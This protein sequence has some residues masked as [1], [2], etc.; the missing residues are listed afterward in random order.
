MFIQNILDYFNSINRISDEEETELEIKILL[1]PRINS[2]DFIKTQS[3]IMDDFKYID[4][5]KKIVANS[6]NFGHSSISQTINFIHTE[7][8]QM[9]VKQLH[10]K[11]GIQIKE[12]RKFYI[13]KSLIKPV[14]LVSNEMNQPSYKLSISNES[15]QK[16]DINSFDI[17]RF[18]LRYTIKF[19]KPELK[20]WKLELTLIKECKNI[21]ISQIKIIRDRLFK[22]NIDCDNFLD[23][24]DWKYSDRVE[25]EMEYIGLG[26]IQLS[27]IKSLDELWKPLYNQNKTYSDCVNQIAQI[28][29]PNM[30]DKFKSG[31]F[32]LKQLGSNPIELTKKCYDS[33]ILPNI[34]DFILTEKTD[35]I[36]SMIII[37]PKLGDCH[38]INKTYKYM[39]IPIIENEEINLIILDAEE[40]NTSEEFSVYYVFDCIWYNKNVS[41]LPFSSAVGL[42]KINTNFELTGDDRLSYIEKVTDKYEFLKLKDF[43]HLNKSDYSEQIKEL[44][45]HLDIS[46]NDSSK[47]LPETD[48]FIYISKYDNY[49]DTRN[50]KWKPI[51][52]MTIDF[53]VKKCPSNLLGIHPY[54]NKDEKTLYILFSGIRS[55]EYKKL[56]IQKF[57][58]YNNMF[59]QVQYKDAY[60]PIQFS[61]SSDPYAYLF[62]S[63]N[64]NLDNNIVELNRVDNEWKLFKVRSDRKI[65]MDRK[66]Y[67]GNYFKYAEYIWMNYSNPLTIEY[68]RNSTSDMNGYFQE[69][70]NS[71][72]K[73]SR[74]FNN[75]VKNTLLQMYVQ[76]K[77][78][79]HCNWVIDLACGKAQDLTK[80]ID[81]DIKNIL[82]I[83]IDISALTEVIHRKYTYI[84]NKHNNHLSNIFIKQLDL[85]ESYKKNIDNIC[86]SPFGILAN[87]VP[88][89]ICNL[90]LHYLIPNK[91]KIQN[92]CNLLNKLLEPGGIFIF[93]AF[94]GKKIF[95][96]LKETDTWHKY[97][98]GKLLFSIKKKYTGD[99]FTGLNQ[100]IDVLLPFSNGMYYTEYLINEDLLENELAKKKIT[101]INKDS[102]GI[103]MNKFK[104]NKPHFYKELTDI[105][106]EFISLYNFYVFNKQKS[107]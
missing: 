45:T 41:N 10:F 4:T 94:N 64:H 44:Q 14:Y 17:I 100:K 73:Y 27:D 19:I 69:D 30:I 99:V 63:D 57:K 46:N 106:S 66:T 76:N 5:I 24:V 84:N 37:Y 16:E 81:C 43:I 91:S 34:N 104:I 36:R 51:E 87:G 33:I 1:D 26:S 90:A 21:P 22:N 29:K 70:D 72:Y 105:D 38:I 61:P 65:D 15:Y 107:R 50:Y 28:I 49:N 2:P 3:A 93:T 62:W 7:K 32:G 11:N 6:V 88:L 68:L 53:V 39:K 42:D 52:K 95:D 31:Q 80:Y 59:K 67:Y 13:K 47:I 97:K 98:D 86:K 89:V 79:E 60:F 83:D 25:L 96:L 56:G 35:G 102:F 103:Y 75:F 20:N 48:G 85:S 78:D 55:N 74:K 23:M 54:I 18:R 77:S 82:M 101:L 71:L 8:N 9:F 58:N 40:Y 92:F 12:K